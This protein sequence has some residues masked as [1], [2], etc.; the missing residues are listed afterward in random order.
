M[1]QG[2]LQRRRSKDDQRTNS[3]RITAA[4]K[5]VLRSASPGADESD[6]TLLHA[7][8]P[9]LRKPFLE[10]LAI[11][12]DEMDKLESQDDKTLSLK[13]KVRKRA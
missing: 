12:A 11:L 1:A 7:V 3:V 2:Y 4:G 13:I 10:A 5:K 8:S 9:S 6:R